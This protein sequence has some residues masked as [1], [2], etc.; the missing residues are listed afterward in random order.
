[1]ACYGLHYCLFMRGQQGRRSRLMA[2][3]SLNGLNQLWSPNH[4]TNLNKVRRN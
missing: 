1:M 4:Q 3:K 2:D